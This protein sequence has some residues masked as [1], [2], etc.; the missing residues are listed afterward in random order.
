MSMIAKAQAE[1]GVSATHTKTLQGLIL[2]MKPQIM[3]A[4]PKVITPERFTR[5]VLTAISK[6]PAL[7]DC[8]PQSFL[9][10]MM[11]AA[12]LGLEPNTPLGQAYLIPY[13][14]HDRLECQ[15]QL[16]YKGLIDLAYRSGEVLDIQAHAVHEHDL[17]EYELGLE[18]RLKHVPAMQDRGPVVAYYAVYHTRAGGYGVEV[19]SVDDVRQYAAKY[20]KSAKKNRGPW[21]TDFDAMAKKT[22][23]KQALKY[24]PIA[25]ELMRATAADET[26]KSTTE[27]GDMLDEP[28]ETV[29]DVAPV[30]VDE[31]EQDHAAETA[32]KE[33][34]RANG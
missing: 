9:G 19:M 16:G 30:A 3:K 31:P 21:A 33:G 2:A 26:I 17:F 1:K 12:Q 23:V 29:I 8:T 4:L 25:T 28:D 5:M 20:S 6:T 10:A 15:F 27:G 14:N 34:A 24:A 32:E 18:T 11:Q 13:Q 22:V 7:A